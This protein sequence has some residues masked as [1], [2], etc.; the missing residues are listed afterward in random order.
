MRS[1]FT[2]HFLTVFLVLMSPL[3][4]FPQSLSE[5][6]CAD[7]IIEAVSTPS[8]K[9]LGNGKLELN[10][11]QGLPPYRIKWEDGNSTAIRKNLLAG[12]Y[13]VE[14]TD[15]LG[16][17]SS[18]VLEVKESAVMRSQLEVTHNKKPNQKKGGI[19][20][21]MNGGKAPYRYSWI[22]NAVTLPQGFVPHLNKMEKLPPGNYR[23]IVF[24][25]LN[26]YHEIDTE[27]R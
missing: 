26:C 10:I 23:I 12:R 19:T 24:D 9:G 1:K 2:T 22:S 3:S 16:C 8:C 17:H 7:L 18:A 20:I 27:V 11:S 14:V 4:L 25:A 6:P 21:H 5:E 13:Q 15:V